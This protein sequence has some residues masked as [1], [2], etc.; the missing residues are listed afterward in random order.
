MS[1][2]RNI[3]QKAFTRVLK[4]ELNSTIVAEFDNT[5]GI[6]Q[7]RRFMS[8]HTAKS[9]K[10]CCDTSHRH[11]AVSKKSKLCGGMKKKEGLAFRALWVCVINFMRISPVLLSWTC[12]QSNS[13]GN[14]CADT[15]MST[16][17]SQ[18]RSQGS[19]SHNLS[20]GISSIAVCDGAD[21]VFTASC[22]VY[23]KRHLLSEVHCCNI[24]QK[25][26]QLNKRMPHSWKHTCG[27]PWGV[28]AC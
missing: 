23:S 15:K 16:E 7:L 1:L 5:Q 4:A 12:S 22:C 9:T 3:W 14:K 18:H 27:S 10:F 21:V 24:I 13:Q 28:F 8:A 26:K 25:K 11:E 17:T 19:H 6:F 2:K 20:Y